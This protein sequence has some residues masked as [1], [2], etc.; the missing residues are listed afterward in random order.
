MISDAHSLE[1]GTDRRAVRERVS[2]IVGRGRRPRREHPITRIGMV[3]DPA[4][5]Q[6]P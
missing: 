1:V 4:R 6:T 3:S 5:H 2:I